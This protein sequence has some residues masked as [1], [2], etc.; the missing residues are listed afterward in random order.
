MT[1]AKSGS[2]M[3]KRQIKGNGWTDS[4][5]EAGCITLNYMLTMEPQLEP[6]T[7]TRL[8][9]I[10]F[11]T[12]GLKTRD[13]KTRDGQKCRTGK[14]ETGKRSTKLQDWKTREKA[15]MESQTAYFTCSI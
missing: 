8:L 14:R 15:C 1:A 2:K 7:F 11:L 12:G 9:L 4:T 10:E 5:A 3:P 13:R 6:A